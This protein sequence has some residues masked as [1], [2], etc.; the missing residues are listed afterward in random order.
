MPGTPRCLQ[1]EV[2]TILSEQRALHLLPPL[3]ACPGEPA[4]YLS[5]QPVSLCVGLAVACMPRCVCTYSA[6]HVGESRIPC[7]PIPT[8]YDAWL[9]SILACLELRRPPLG[10]AHLSTSCCAC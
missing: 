5:P 6:F 3:H 8:I 10:R 7:H 9:P 4:D 2:L 1:T